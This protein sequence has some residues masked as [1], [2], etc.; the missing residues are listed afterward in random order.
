[1]GNT[2]TRAYLVSFNLASAAGW[3][4]VG[5][6]LIK[7]WT[8][9]FSPLANYLDLAAGAA[10]VAAQGAGI[11]SVLEPVQT[12]AV[13]EVIHP[14]VGLVR[15]GVFLTFLQVLS[16]QL[17][18]WGQ[19]H[20]FLAETIT[21]N[22][23]FFS[24]MVAAWSITEVIRYT[25]YALKQLNIEI[26]PLTF[27][28][29]TLFIVLYPAGVSGELSCL[30]AS[31]WPIWAK[32]LAV[33]S[34]IIGF[35]PLYFHMWAQRKKVLNPR[36][37]PPVVG[38]QWPE[39][40]DKR[41]GKMDRSSTQTSKAIFAASVARVNRDAE[42]AINRTKNWRHGYPR[43]AV[44]NVELSCNSTQDCL[45][46]ARDGLTKAHSLFTFVRDNEETSLNKAMKKFSKNDIFETCEMKGSVKGGI[47]ELV[48]PYKSFTEGKGA[49]ER[50]L[51][52]KELIDQLD[53]W[54]ANGTIEPSCRDA[55]QFVAENPK[56]RDLSDH[57][58]CLLGAGA[59]MGPLIL[60][61]SMGANVIAVD[62]HAKPVWE[63]I[64]KR[65]K[66]SSGRIIFPV[67]KS[68]IGE[69]DV[70]TL[71]EAEL[72]PISGCDLFTDTPEIASWIISV[73]K[74]KNCKNLTI[75]G[76]VY[77]PGERFVRAAM[78][79]DAIQ[80]AVMDNIKGVSLGFLC[81]PTD[82]FVVDK[83]TRDASR[84]FRKESPLGFSWLFKLLLGKKALVSNEGA[85][86]TENGGEYDI[87]NGIVVEQ[88]PN[89]ALAK[90]IQHW[91]CMLAYS[92]G[93]V[94]S[95]N[96]APSTATQSVLQNASFAA[97]YNGFKNFKAMEVMYQETS[98]AVMCALLIH[99]ILNPSSAKNP[100]TKKLKNP[101]Q[102]FAT[103]AFHGGV[104]RC[105]Y[106]VG[107][108]EVGNEEI[109]IKNS[110]LLIPNVIPRP[111]SL[112]FQGAGQYQD[113][114]LPGPQKVL[115]GP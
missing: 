22:G 17:V 95:S 76:Y 19:L 53:A 102:L 90:R 21:N 33:L 86:K 55:I 59:A 68:K 29:Y 20:P 71:S 108:I 73:A 42:Q 34:Y 115:F 51:Q 106:Q 7:A 91:R 105:P 28:R 96:I 100:K 64:F 113:Q 45:T 84:K 60:L 56:C 109:E 14:L 23:A 6:L 36:K 101:I 30:F 67:R 32:D 3:G 69:K 24:L 48:I 75:G 97:A 12:L 63:N 94:A 1:M 83:E 98:N 16:R 43:H 88:G 62:Y 111:H 38:V 47:K 81:S 110:R 35:P 39:V 31:R 112:R 5:Y 92:D 85:G 78:A 104:W 15:T 26:Q 13:M 8:N 87:V 70:R 103:G 2:I 79:M 114:G 72:A 57:Y 89:Y 46:I 80:E 65:V 11:L 107:S 9:N 37:P 82:V 40:M 58:F 49:V 99:D 4:Y 54:V 52:G 44:K 77:L 18:V 93:N 61:L 41:K 50:N 74:E 10:N 66:G 25:S 27:L